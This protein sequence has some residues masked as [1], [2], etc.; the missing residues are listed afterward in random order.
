[1]IKQHDFILSG[2]LV[3]VGEIKQGQTEINVFMVNLILEMLVNCFCL[4]Y[5]DT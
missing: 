1:M 3:S 2:S 5:K 4:V